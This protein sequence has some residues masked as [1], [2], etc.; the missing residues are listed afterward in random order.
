MQQKLNKYSWIKFKDGGTAFNQS[1]FNA[2]FL[3]N[4]L[5]SYKF[6]KLFYTYFLN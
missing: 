4:Y 6:L 1:L 5:K 2:R 3:K